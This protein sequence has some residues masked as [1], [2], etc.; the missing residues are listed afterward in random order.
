[1]IYPS[2]QSYTFHFFFNKMSFLLKK[3]NKTKLMSM[4]GRFYPFRARGS[5]SKSE[6]EEFHPSLTAQACP[7]SFSLCRAVLCSPLIVAVVLISSIAHF[8]IPLSGFFATFEIILPS[9]FSPATQLFYCFSVPILSIPKPHVS[10]Y[11]D[12]TKKHVYK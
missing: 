10:L 8:F 12:S 7:L 1:M 2:I 6:S 4:F 5:D 11:V 3:Q 9:K